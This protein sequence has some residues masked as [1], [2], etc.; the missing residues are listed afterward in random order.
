MYVY[1]LIGDT[2]AREDLHSRINI[3]PLHLA[4]IQGESYCGRPCQHDGS[5]RRLIAGDIELEIQACIK[6]VLRILRKTYPKIRASVVVLSEQIGRSRNASQTKQ[7]Y[8]C[9]R[10]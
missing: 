9:K 5:G 8:D 3:Y 2:I 10:G 6:F 7:E 4:R 1:T